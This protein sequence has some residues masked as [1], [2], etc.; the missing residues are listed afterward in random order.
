MT[1]KRKY[2][3]EHLTVF[4]VVL[5]SI[6]LHAAG[7]GMNTN[8]GKKIAVIVRSIA[9]GLCTPA[10]RYIPSIKHEFKKLT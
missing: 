8:D 1:S 2:I 6:D 3:A 9:L 10:N 7:I 5:V 4:K